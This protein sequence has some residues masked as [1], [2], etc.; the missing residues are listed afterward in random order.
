M[1]G[2]FDILFAGQ[3]SAKVLKL[4][5]PISFWGGVDQ[6]TGVIIDHTHPQQGVCVT[7]KV[8]IVPMIRGSGGTPG[9]L[10]TLLK[11]GKAPAALVLNHACMNVLTAVMVGEKLYG[12]RC[13]VFLALAEQTDNLDGTMLDIDEQ[14][15]WFTK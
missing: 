11:L 9:S 14:G 6:Y 15:K 12:K 4:D 2:Y 10:A 3:V 7:D 5:S 13:P 1:S 8:L